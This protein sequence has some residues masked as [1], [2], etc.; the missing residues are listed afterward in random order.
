MQCDAMRC[1]VVHFIQETVQSKQQRVRVSVPFPCHYR[2]LPMY[3]LAVRSGIHKFFGNDVKSSA[4]LLLSR[5]KVALFGVTS[6][7]PEVEAG[8]EA[9]EGDRAELL[10]GVR[11]TG[12]EF[13]VD[14]D[15]ED[16]AEEE[17]GVVVED[18]CW[19]YNL[20]I[21]SER[22]LCAVSN[23]PTTYKY[24]EKQYKLQDLWHMSYHSNAVQ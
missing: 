3:F 1:N 9:E 18:S 12:E 23:F 15:E 2:S 11:F 24:Q 4:D 8:V 13:E 16:E 21:R 20:V 19:R 7:P 22:L 5:V 6:I 17:E 10:D 14:E